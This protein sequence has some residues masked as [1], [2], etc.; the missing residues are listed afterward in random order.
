MPG[1]YPTV[2][3]YL[4]YEDAGAAMD[5]LVNAFGFRER[6]RMD[7][8]DGRVG[9]GELELGEGGVVMLGEPGSGYENPN[10][11]G[12]R[13]TAGVHVYVDDVDAH[14]E[15]AKAAGA[16]INTEPTDQ[17]YGDRR[18]DCEDLEGHDWFFAQQLTR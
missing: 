12:G 11:R 1:E 13:A 18:Y 10:A 14:Y 5:W 2:A 6:M 3:P 8:D 15:H 9:H 17:E 16:K 4:Y 7:N